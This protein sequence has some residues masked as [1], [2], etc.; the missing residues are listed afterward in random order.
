MAQKG[1][2][3]RSNRFQLV[4]D[5]ENRLANRSPRTMRS[6][7]RRAAMRDWSGQ[8]RQFQIKV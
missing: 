7:T 2:S 4:G 5:R 6:T 8:G 3:N 1:A